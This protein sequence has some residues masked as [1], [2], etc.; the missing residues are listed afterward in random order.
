M[1]HRFF[2]TPIYYA[3]DVPHLGHFYTTVAADILARFWRL[4]GDQV[5]LTSGTDEHGGKIAAAA[6]ER[7]T[8]A[9]A[10]VD[11]MAKAF[12][13]MTEY[14][15][16]QID[17]FVRTTQPRHAA[18]ATS[19][20]THLVDAGMIYLGHYEGWYAVRDE[21]FY[22]ESELV[23]TPQ[24]PRAPSGAEVQWMQEPCYFFR[25]SAFA[26]RLIDH[27]TDNP[28]AIAP[29]SRYNEV[30]SFLR[31]GLRDLAVSRANVRWG[32][33][34][35]SDP[36]H[37]MYVWI[38]ALANYL[39]VLGYPHT[40]DESSQS[41]PE[42]LAYARSCTHLLGKDIL[43]FHA[44][45]WP[46]L[47]MAAGLPLPRRIF[48]HGWWLCEGEKM[49]K[50]LGNVID[51]KQ[52]IDRY[53]LDS[54][55]Y[56]LFRHVRF[57][58]DG[59]CA[60]SLL[61]SRLNQEL[62]DRLG[63]LAHRVLT[64]VHKTYGGAMPTCPID[65]MDPDAQTLTLWGSAILDDLRAKMD[66]QDLHGY[67][68]SI[69][70]AILRGNQFMTDLAP[71]T[72]AKQGDDPMA[73]ARMRGGLSALMH[74]LRDVAILLLPVMPESAEKLLH[75]VDNQARLPKDWI[76]K[77]AQSQFDGLA[78]E[79]SPARLA[80][81]FTA[82]SLCDPNDSSDNT[83]GL[84]SIGTALLATTVDVPSILFTKIEDPSQSPVAQHSPKEPS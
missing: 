69:Y 57:G 50:S 76:C 60:E 70:H 55:R 73:V 80:A 75:L 10:H 37:V 65:Q 62:A 33:G 49:S 16:V 43:R 42:A 21:A 26:Q 24:G 11:H 13:E 35:P 7:G 71:W 64:F 34:V 9:Q 44:V 3:N 61:R 39:T 79:R 8:S 47:L 14:A 83:V 18:C 17:D 53:G 72:L 15:G 81:P 51:P 59:D 45:Y 63:N 52:L 78:G 56:F 77:M 22:E 38:D 30:M 40:F 36:G 20:W 48:A 54:V 23:Q 5:W 19:L 67:L 46:A 2:T 25:L 28:D 6:A 1:T 66:Q 84:A 31:G 68:E 4:N 58:G 82:Q 12:L 29:E 27:Y 41:A 32:I 74:L